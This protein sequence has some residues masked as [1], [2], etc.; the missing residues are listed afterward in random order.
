MLVA[1][2]QVIP[3]SVVGADMEHPRAT[4]VGAVEARTSDVGRLAQLV[5]ALA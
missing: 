3:G 4:E 2:G 1:A 5:R